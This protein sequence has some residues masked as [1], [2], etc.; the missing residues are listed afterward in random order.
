[1]DFEILKNKKICENKETLDT[2]EN[3]AEIYEEIKEVIYIKI[4]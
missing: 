2:Y 1:L 3:A 4:N